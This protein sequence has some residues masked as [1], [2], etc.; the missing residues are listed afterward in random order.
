MVIS[1]SAAARMLLLHDV[2]DLKPVKQQTL[3]MAL[4]STLDNVHTQIYCCRA[5]QRLSLVGQRALQSRL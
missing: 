1:N 5:V 3:L 4:H 2:P